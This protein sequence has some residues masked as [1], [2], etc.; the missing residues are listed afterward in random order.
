MDE[1]ENTFAA[2]S[3]MGITAWR[4]E[5]AETKEEQRRKKLFCLK[6]DKVK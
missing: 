6:K 1:G 5:R 4:C 2:R 3:K